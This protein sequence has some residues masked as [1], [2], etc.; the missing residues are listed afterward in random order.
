MVV[1][2]SFQGD[3]PDMLAILD[4]DDNVV[5]TLSLDFFRKYYVE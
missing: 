1:Y 5:D 3:S 4:D 2:G